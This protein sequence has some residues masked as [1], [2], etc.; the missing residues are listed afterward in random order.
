MYCVSINKL[1]FFIQFAVSFYR[2][3]KKKERKAI[4]VNVTLNKI[5]RAEIETYLCQISS[6][7]WFLCDDK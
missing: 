4:L 6:I 3:E 7:E 2:Q 5:V 1:Y